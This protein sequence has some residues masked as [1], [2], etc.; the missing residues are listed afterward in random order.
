MEPEAKYAIVGGAVLILVALLVGAV[1]WL[2][3]TGQGGDARQYMIYFER[4]SLEGLELRSNVTMRGVRVGSVSGMR[5]S[6]GRPGAVE[7]IITV[8]P[9]TPVRT[10]TS[11]TVQR[12]LVTGLA[13]V[14]LANA[15][16]DTPL[17]DK[18]PPDEPHPVIA[19]GESQ[20][21]QVSQDLTQLV[22]RA[23]ETMRR[24]NATLT[25]ENR[26]ALTD[27]L[28]N[29]R[30]VS[31]HADTTL[32]K[33]DAASVSI[34]GAAKSV[35][36]L[37]DAVSLD[38]R[39]LVER[40]DA[41]G[42]DTTAAVRD[43]GEAARTISA[44]AQRLSRRAD[45]LAATADDELRNTAQALRAAADQVGAAASRLREP[46]QAL[47]GPSEAALGPGETR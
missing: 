19:E 4:Q 29:L 25:A 47:F 5:F 23:S 13:T 44:D 28:D 37:A 6:P 1:L 2:R 39:R 7:V 35:R 41:L 46:R 24:L 14:R 45:A 12:N 10:S 33:V 15:A 43:I 20:L 9:S 8:E 18:A 36:V 27:I 11:A 26:A 3:G 31:Q 38:S 22:Q 32:E 30:R 16:E 17:L 34:G 42:A 40:Y 21:E